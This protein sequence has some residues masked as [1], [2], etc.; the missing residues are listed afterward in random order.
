MCFAVTDSYV[1][2]RC[3]LPVHMS[4]RFIWA[5]SSATAS[6]HTLFLSARHS[7]VRLGCPALSQ[8]PGSVK[9]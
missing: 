7:D 3:D 5:E 2:I 1:S 8:E 9:G 4:V 6:A